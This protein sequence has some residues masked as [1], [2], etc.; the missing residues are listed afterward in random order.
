LI[1]IVESLSNPKIQLHPW[2]DTLTEDHDIAIPIESL[3][4]AKL[5][6]LAAFMRDPEAHLSEVQSTYRKM[7]TDI[8][9][10]RRN[11]SIISQQGEASK[12]LH[13][14][15]QTA[16]GIL[17]TFAIILN[18]ILHSFE[19]DNAELVEQCANLVN[20][21]IVL[22]EDASR[23]R[24]LGSSSMPLCLVSA[25]VATN[26]VSQRGRLEEI[27]AEYQSDFAIARWM[28]VAAWLQKYLKKH[29]TFLTRRH[30]RSTNEAEIAL[31]K[32]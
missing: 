4:L 9:V 20:Q 16:Y 30:V 7:A 13:C 12:T 32:A 22:A 17:L 25:W 2:L 18:I 28:D 23:Y 10:V 27:L 15:C 5:A 19:A 26:E 14:R 11:T 29:P 21:V 1:Q 24:P 31:Q 8:P 6:R 3:K